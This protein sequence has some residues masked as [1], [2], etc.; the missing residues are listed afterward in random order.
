M[1]TIDIQANHRAP[2]SCSTL[3]FRISS[4]IRTQTT[5]E[6]LRLT[7]VE[8]YLSRFQDSPCALTTGKKLHKLPLACPPFIL[9]FSQMIIM[10]FFRKMYTETYRTTFA[11]TPLPS[12][13]GSAASETMFFAAK[14]S[15]NKREKSEWAH[16]GRFKSVK[17]GQPLA[18]EVMPSRV[19]AG[20]W[21]SDSRL[22]E[23]SPPP[24]ARSAVLET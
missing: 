1:S 22:S 9:L 6:A 20:H 16:I 24:M 15:R 12:C 13:H 18:T 17:L 14:T 21:A 3:P 7:V 11:S 4:T 5:G 19:R 10:A 2:A 23:C 8:K